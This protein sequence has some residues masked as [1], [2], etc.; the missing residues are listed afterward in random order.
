MPDLF[1]PLS[2]TAV[3]SC[4]S[5]ERARNI[6]ANTGSAGTKVIPGSTIK[7]TNVKYRQPV[8]QGTRPVSGSRC[9]LR[10]GR[11]DSVLKMTPFGMNT[12]EFE[13]TGAEPPVHQKCEDPN[14]FPTQTHTDDT[15]QIAAFCLGNPGVGGS[16]PPLPTQESKGFPMNFGNPLFVEDRQRLVL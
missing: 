2:L 15:L 13:H 12:G 7:M 10:R 16:I 3:D 8:V 14:V 9:S 6:A 1:G 5:I 4:S 11:R